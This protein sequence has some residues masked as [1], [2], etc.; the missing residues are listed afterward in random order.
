MLIQ[1]LLIGIMVLALG[2]TWRRAQ[3]QVIPPIE[4]IVWS[5]L[6]IGAA[7]VILLPNVTTVVARFF[8]VGRGAD[9]VLYGSAV[10]L[11]F[12]V[13]KLFISMEKLERKLTDMVRRDALRD[14]EG[15][16]KKE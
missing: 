11:F 3:Q 16:K 9:F 5:F 10:T 4:A 8:G 14:L 2:V 6:W 7:V 13:F 15:G 12:L 1:V